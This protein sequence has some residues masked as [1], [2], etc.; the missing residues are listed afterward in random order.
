MIEKRRGFDR[1]ATQLTVTYFDGDRFLTEAVHNAS[2]GGV[3]IKSS[4]L[5]MWDRSW[6]WLLIFM[7][8]GKPKAWSL[9]LKRM[10]T[11]IA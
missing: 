11:S 2:P 3:M 9:G 1:V 10:I 8:L 5:H 6:T 4:G 7:S